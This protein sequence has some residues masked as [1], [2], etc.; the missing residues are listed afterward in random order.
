MYSDALVAQKGDQVRIA[1]GFLARGFGAQPVKGTLEI[2]AKLV[3]AKDEHGY[4]NYVEASFDDLKVTD[5]SVKITS[6]GDL[7]NRVRTQ[8]LLI[9]AFTVF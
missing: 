5:V 7:K 4:P 8:L 9:L 6:P 2:E 1:S 3:L